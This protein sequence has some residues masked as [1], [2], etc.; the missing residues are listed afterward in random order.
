MA[1]L[2]GRARAWVPPP[3][4]PLP[5]PGCPGGCWFDFT[6]QKPQRKEAG[7][8]TPRAPRLITLIAT[9]A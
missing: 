3:T 8:C 2:R 4:T 7:G 9:T 5:Y 6:D 1:D